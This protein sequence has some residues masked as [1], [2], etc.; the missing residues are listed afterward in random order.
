MFIL[1]HLITPEYCRGPMTR[2]I[3][4]RPIGANRRAI[5][6]RLNAVP[7][8]WTIEAS[9]IFR[10]CG[11]EY[12]GLFYVINCYAIASN[13]GSVNLAF[14][15]VK[16][17]FPNNPEIVSYSPAGGILYKVHLPNIVLW[18]PTPSFL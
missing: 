7:A 2:L 16:V 18:P 13:V 5:R 9:T 12:G 8:T 11:F 6:Q 10:V 4:G 14:S 17:H 15:V 3:S 1:K